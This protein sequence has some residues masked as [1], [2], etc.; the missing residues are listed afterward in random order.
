[1]L[2][3][4]NSR[5]FL[6]SK[7]LQRGLYFQTA[8]ENF[9]KRQMLKSIAASKQLF[10]HWGEPPGLPDWEEERVALQRMSP[11]HRHLFKF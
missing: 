10:P 11:F 5:V 7:S 9:M 6:L 8:R 4:E 2:S 3:G 1:V